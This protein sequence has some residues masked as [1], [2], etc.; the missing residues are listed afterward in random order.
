MFARGRKIHDRIINLCCSSFV[1]QPLPFTCSKNRVQ[2]CINIA[3]K[4]LHNTHSISWWC[5]LSFQRWIACPFPTIALNWDLTVYLS[6]HPSIPSLKKLSWCCR[7]K[8]NQN[9]GLGPKVCL[10]NILSPPSWFMPFILCLFP[11]T[12][13]DSYLAGWVLNSEISVHEYHW[14]FQVGENIVI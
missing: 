6:I 11:V 12:P 14:S 13:D 4:L 2:T 8:C 10:Q 9:M 1:L 7:E 5:Q 3:K